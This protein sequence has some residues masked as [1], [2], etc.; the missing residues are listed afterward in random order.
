MKISNV[1][2]R[3]T[4]LLYV[5]DAVVAC[6]HDGNRSQEPR[7]ALKAR[8]EAGIEVMRPQIH[9]RVQKLQAHLSFLPRSWF[10]DPYHVTLPNVQG[11]F[12]W[13]DFDNLSAFQSESPLESEPFCRAIDYEAGN[14]F[15][16]SFKIDDKTGA[17]FQDNPL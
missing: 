6:R 13:D 17:L 8:A 5:V 2:E 15:G 4:P 16:N 12:V 14:P 1:W 9:N 10:A 3:V 11:V 7:G